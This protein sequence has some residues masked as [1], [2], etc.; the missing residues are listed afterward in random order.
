MKNAIWLLS[1]CMSFYS[2]GL[3]VRLAWV[4]IA[5]HDV[6]HKRLNCAPEYNLCDYYCQRF[7]ENYVAALDDPLKRLETSHKQ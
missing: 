1:M 2:L 5:K 6:T 7:Y 4:H 3:C